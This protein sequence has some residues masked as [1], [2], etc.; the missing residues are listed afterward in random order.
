MEKIIEVESPRW[1]NILCQNNKI[2]QVKEPKL[3][4]KDFFFSPAPPGLLKYNIDT[5]ASPYAVW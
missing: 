5:K 2:I 1:P 4:T 3:N